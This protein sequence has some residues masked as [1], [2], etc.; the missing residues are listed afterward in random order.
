VS[1][2]RRDTGSISTRR[3]YRIR[4][5]RRKAEDRDVISTWQIVIAGLLTGLAIGVAARTVGWSSRSTA[6]A[7]ALGC[8]LVIGWR[9]VAN[10]LVL[11]DDFLPTIS[12]GDLGCLPVGAIGPAIVTLVAPRSGPRPRLPAVVGGLSAFMINVVIL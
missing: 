5:Q 10:L 4:R 8:L 11:N 12:V 7:A 2:L 3:D 6:T 9:A 1:T